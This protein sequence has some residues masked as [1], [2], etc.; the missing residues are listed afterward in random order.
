M[1]CKTRFTVT[2]KLERDSEMHQIKAVI[3][4]FIGTL[5]NVV[6]Y[7][8]ESSKMKL[9]Q[10]IIEA[11]FETSTEEFLQAYSQAHEKYRVI[12]YEQL[13]EVT[14]AVWI[15]EALNRL[16]FNTKPED[17]NIKTAV[18]AFFEDY[19]K[20]LEL[21]PYAKNLLRKLSATYKL[22]LISNFTFAPVIYAGLKKLDINQYFN[23]ILVSDDAGWRKPNINIFK[24]ALGRLKVTAEETVYVGDS[25]QEDIKGAKA[26]GM[27]TV[28]V[29]SQFY[30][31]ENL[32]ESKQEPDLIVK[33]LCELCKELPKLVNRKII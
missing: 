14:N 23:V 15:S 8:M 27:K 13:V 29:P 16:G 12:R 25:P 33:D 32:S 19:I 30:T 11:G 9:A 3:F 6:D 21:R 31:L 1:H 4:D 20:T 5:T 7:D 28:F 24:E 26:I 22:G 10:A 18:N 17:M 2:K